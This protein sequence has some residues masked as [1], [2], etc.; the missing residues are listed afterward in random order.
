[1]E[2][3]RTPEIEEDERVP[4]ERVIAELGWARATVMRYLA[5]ARRLVQTF[6][7][8]QDKRKKL[9]PLKTTAKLLRRE[10]GR[11]QARRMRGRDEA[12]GYWSALA[13]LKVATG[14]LQELSREVAAVSGDVK[15]AF[16]GLRRRPPLVV[17]IR[18]LPDPGL[19]L[20][21]PLTVLVSPLRLTLWKATVPELLPLRGERL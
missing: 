12:A 10:H 6:P 13:S 15:A 18:A 2:R 1:M 4:L 9:Y 11:V 21:R 8:P 20:V 14:R 19:D 7:D 16:E 3:E 5:A 17:E